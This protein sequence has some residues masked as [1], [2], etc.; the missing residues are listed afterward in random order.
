M[1]AMLAEAA[2]VSAEFDLARTRRLF[3]AAEHAAGLIGDPYG[4][5]LAFAAVAGALAASNQAEAARQPK[6]ARLFDA[7]E[8]AASLIRETEPHS[9]AFAAIVREMADSDPGRAK[10]I[11]WKI[12]DPDQKAWA[13]AH[14]A[15]A[16]ARSDP[17]EAE[18]IAKS[19]TSNW[20]KSWALIALVEAARVREERAHQALAEPRGEQTLT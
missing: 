8:G 10:D 11:A 13:L 6:S 7:A 20:P 16:L 17:A 5:A 12:P 4:R 19:I 3:D 14:V 2:R 15:K 9:K 1:A 18:I